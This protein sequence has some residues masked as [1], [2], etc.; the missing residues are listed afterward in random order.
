MKALIGFKVFYFFVSV[1]FRCVC[2]MALRIA[3]PFQISLVIMSGRVE[4]LSPGPFY[5]GFTVFQLTS[6]VTAFVCHISSYIDNPKIL[7]QLATL[8]VVAQFVA[9]A[10]RLP[11]F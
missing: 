7:Q 2:E 6:L 4:F 3:R 10:M 5:T 8:G 11:W 9:M 1:W